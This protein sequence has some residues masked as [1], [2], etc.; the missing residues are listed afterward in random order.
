M[1]WSQESTN[2]NRSVLD[3][4]VRGSLIEAE[5]MVERLVGF[6]LLNMYVPTLLGVILRTVIFKDLLAELDGPGRQ[7]V[8]VYSLWPYVCVKSQKVIWAIGLIREILLPGYV[9]AFLLTWGK[10]EVFAGYFTMTFSSINTTPTSGG[11]PKVS[12]IKAMDIWF[13]CLSDFYFYFTYR[14]CPRNY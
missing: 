10:D 14:I 5:F 4:V 12:Y 9:S 8:R 13:F 6:Y 3:Q 11:L 7:S 1:Y 2:Q